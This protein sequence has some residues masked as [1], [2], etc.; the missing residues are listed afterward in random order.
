MFNE[1]MTEVE[2]DLAM[3]EGLR[4]LPVP[5]P[6]GDFDHKVLS[7]LREQTPWWQAMLPGLRPLIAGVACSLVMTMALV[8]WVM[9]APLPGPATARSA[10]ASVVSGSAAASVESHR[11]VSSA[12]NPE[13]AL[14]RSDI[15]ASSL[16]RL[17][18]RRP[19]APAAPSPGAVPKRAPTGRPHRPDQSRLPDYTFSPIA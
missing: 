15:T 19:Q 2:I 14:D 10:G 13:D 9:N 8:R 3:R 4:D 5:Q 16:A 7:A 12:G 11:A 6:S 17:M 18:T 1:K